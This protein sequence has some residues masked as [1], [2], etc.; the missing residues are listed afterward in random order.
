MVSRWYDVLGRVF[1]FAGPKTAAFTVE[2]IGTFFLVLTIGLNVTQGDKYTA[3]IAIGSI[4]MVMIFMGGHISGAHYNPAVTFGVRLTGRDHI[5]T[6]RAM[7]YLAMQ[8]LAA[9]SGAAAA[10]GITGKSFATLPGPGQG[11][12]EVFFVE[13]LYTFALVSVMLNCATTRSQSM[14]SFFGLAIGFTVA[15]GAYSVGSISGGAFNPAVAFGSTLVHGIASKGTFKYLWVY[16]IAELMGSL[17][18]A[19]V[20]RITND[21]EYRKQAAIAKVDHQSVNY[22]EIPSTE[23]EI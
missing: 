6:L 13:F 4:L 17:F 23:E 20:F 3:P 10:Y 22:R 2:F 14:N 19:I 15:S 11:Y 8:L 1:R 9:T 7:C 21:S 5:S 16:W 12:T 18:A